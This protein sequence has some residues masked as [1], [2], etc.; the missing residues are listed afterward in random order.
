MQLGLVRVC[1]Y[2]L[3]MFKSGED[4]LWERQLYITK[5]KQTMQN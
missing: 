2:L 5:K 3:N 1:I 4:N